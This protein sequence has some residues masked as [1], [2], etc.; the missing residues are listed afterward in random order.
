MKLL[1]ETGYAECNESYYWQPNDWTYF[2]NI[3]D[4]LG[5]VHYTFN[6]ETGENVGYT[7]YYGFGME[8]KME[9]SWR[10]EAAP[11]V[12]GKEKFSG[13]ELQAD[14][15]LNL[16]D[17]VW[18]SYDPATGRFTT[19]DPLAEKYYSISPYVYCVNNP[20]RFVDPDGMDYWSTNNQ[21]EIE[22]FLGA[23][24]LGGTQNIFEKFNF[25]SWTHVE[26]NEFVGNLTF[27]D[28][29]N[30]F[31]SSYGSIE[32][33][34]ITVTGISIGAN[35][36]YDGTASVNTM[37]GDWYNKSSGG[38]QNTHPEFGLLLGG[39][40]V[41]TAALKYLWNQMSSPMGTTNTFD[42]N[43]SGFAK[44]STKNERKI[45]TKRADVWKEREMQLR[46]QLK[47][48]KTNVEKNKIKKDIEHAVNQ[49]RKSEPHGKAGQGH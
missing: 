40:T 19:M 46:E 24:Q 28:E 47:T 21:Q 2:C 29:T 5:S 25:S 34:K 1:T 12:P 41:G 45:N 33:G 31:Y 35:A 7:H 4:H 36:I 49:Q 48:A 14:F 22:R 10:N 3:Q 43:K 38:L 15:G 23:L 9:K 39:T 16:Y 42:A 6:A 18:R 11:G 26:D 13:K 44:G 20:L 17:F 27:N 37:I 30:T 8:D 32:N